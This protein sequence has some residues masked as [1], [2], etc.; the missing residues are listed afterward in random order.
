MQNFSNLVQREH[1]QIR[2]LMDWGKK[3]LRF[4]TEIWLYL[5]NGDRY[6]QGYY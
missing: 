1:F 3:S 2:D 6:G 4:S 5:G